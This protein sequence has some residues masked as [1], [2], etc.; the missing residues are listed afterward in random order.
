[1]ILEGT[2][3]EIGQEK[4]A[5]IQMKEDQ[6]ETISDKK[7]AAPGTGITDIAN[8]HLPHINLPGQETEMM[9]KF[10]VSA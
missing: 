1:M 3:M 9:I 7:G 6:G 8:D 10:P 5:L 2:D 4:G